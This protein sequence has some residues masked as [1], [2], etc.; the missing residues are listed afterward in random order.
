MRYRDEGLTPE[1]PREC[2]EKFAQ[3]MKMCKNFETICEMLQQEQ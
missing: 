2:P 3:L 1:I